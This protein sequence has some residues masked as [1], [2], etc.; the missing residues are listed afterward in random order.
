M[1]S[2]QYLMGLTVLTVV[3]RATLLAATLPNERRMATPGQSSRRP[4]PV[5]ARSPLKT[6]T[7]LV[8]CPVRP[9]RRM[10]VK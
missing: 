5:R 7:T 10:D 6:S 4:M 2:W 9:G 8:Q 3:L 1:K